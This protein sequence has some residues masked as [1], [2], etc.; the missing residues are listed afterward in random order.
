[1]PH[2]DAILA[3]MRKAAIPPYAYTTSLEKEKQIALSRSVMNKEYTSGPHGLRSYVLTTDVSKVFAKVTKTCAVM[4]K[5]LVIH[6]RKVRYATLAEVAVA[7][8]KSE[9][10]QDFEETFGRGHI[11]IGDIGRNIEAYTVDVWNDIQAFL[12]LH[13]SRGGALVIGITCADPID[14]SHDMNLSLSDF[15]PIEVR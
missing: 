1:M 4:A 9:L 5:E 13:L 2:N 6:Q 14:W 8:R 11:V 3:R 7:I 10:P 12:V 15:T